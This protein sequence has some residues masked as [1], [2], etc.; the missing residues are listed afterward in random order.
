MKSKFS[1]WGMSAPMGE[2]LRY[3][4][5]EQLTEDLKNYGFEGTPLVYDWSECCVEGRATYYQDGHLDNFSGV[6]ICDSFGVVLASGW[7]EFIHEPD[8]FLVYWDHL[9][10]LTPTPVLSGK[11]EFGIPAHIW[12]KIP[13]HLRWNYE[14]RR[15]GLV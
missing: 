2:K 14:G 1:D 9:D 5:Q 3:L 13:E 6:S 10:I 8:F 11:L 4:V 7:L 12:E 15:M